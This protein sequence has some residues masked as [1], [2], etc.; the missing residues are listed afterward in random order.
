MH[1]LD[2]CSPYPPRTHSL[3]PWWA[4][5]AGTMENLAPREAGRQPSWHRPASAPLQPRGLHHTG[6]LGQSPGDG[7]AAAAVYLGS[8]NTALQGGPAG[9]GGQGRDREGWEAPAPTM[10]HLLGSS[11]HW[12]T[13]APSNPGPR[14]LVT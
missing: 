14:G 3:D 2:T 9:W 5:W 12:D 4:G 10:G 11:C 6:C 13:A 1:A 7:Q 8:V